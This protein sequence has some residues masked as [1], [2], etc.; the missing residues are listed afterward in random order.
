M[1]GEIRL[2]S[3]GP[4]PNVLRPLAPGDQCVGHGSGYGITSSRCE[5]ALSGTWLLD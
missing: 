1:K 2:C 3:W 5:R 4:Y